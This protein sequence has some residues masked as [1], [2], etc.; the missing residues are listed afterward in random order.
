MD[1]YERY[2]IENIVYFGIFGFNT[3][4]LKGVWGSAIERER[5]RSEKRG[6]GRR[7]GVRRGEREARSEKR[8][9]RSEK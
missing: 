8:E 6:G 9:A 2:I 4:W 7:G 3:Q 5:A 1:I